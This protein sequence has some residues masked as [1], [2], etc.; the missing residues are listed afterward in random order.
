MEK[1]YHKHCRTSGL[2]E[3]SLNSWKIMS[4][5]TS[6]SILTVLLLLASCGYSKPQTRVDPDVTIAPKL[7]EFNPS[8]STSNGSTLQDILQELSRLDTNER[9]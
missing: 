3:D 5:N 4:L 7:L 8:A 2:S 1:E 6:L 9:Y